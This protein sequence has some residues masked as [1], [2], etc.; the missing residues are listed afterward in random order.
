MTSDKQKRKIWNKGKKISGKNPDAWRK[1][2]YGNVIRSGSYGTEGEFG[3]E[4]D[5]KKPKS[6]GGSDSLINKQPLHWLENRKKADKLNYRK[7][8]RK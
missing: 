8:K 3:W 1:D 6:K 4:I 5:H 7:R 2:K